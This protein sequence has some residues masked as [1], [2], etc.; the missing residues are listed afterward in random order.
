MNQNKNSPN[1][2]QQTSRTS[3][4][5]ISKKI[6]PHPLTHLKFSIFHQIFYVFQKKIVNA[7][8]KGRNIW[9][10]H[11][12][13]EGEKKQKKDQVKKTSNFNLSSN[14][15]QI[16][17]AFELKKPSQKQKPSFISWIQS[18]KSKVV[19]DSFYNYKSSFVCLVCF[20][21]LV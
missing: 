15:L 8:T 1:I 4:C 6:L 13:R 11:L 19:V 20:V 2:L 12:E 5:Y 9:L 17:N 21:C 10:R 18:L 7:F 3:L 16:F 14:Y